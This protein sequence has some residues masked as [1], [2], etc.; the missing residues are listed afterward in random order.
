MLMQTWKLTALLLVAWPGQ[1]RDRD[2]RTEK[3]EARAVATE[4][5][6]TSQT[7]DYNS[8]ASWRSG[9][10]PGAGGDDT[11]TAMLDGKYSQRAVSSGLVPG[12]NAIHRVITGPAYGGNIGGSG[13]PLT[14]NIPSSSNTGAMF[15]H[16][17]S[18]SVYFKGITTFADIV[19]DSVNLVN[20]MTLSGRLRH[21]FVK[22]GNVTI[23]T[24]VT[25]ISSITLL[26]YNA[27]VTFVESGDLAPARVKIIGGHMVNE[28]D[29]GAD[30]V[31]EV[32]GG[33]L[34]QIGKML[35]TTDLIIS[36]GSVLYAPTV[37]VSTDNPDMW[38]L[39][40]YLDL[41][42]MAQVLQ[43]TDLVIGPNMKVIGDLIGTGNP[44]GLGIS[45]DLRHDNP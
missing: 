37:D 27:T 34:E 32:L 43:A 41:S 39:A 31:I 4:H 25:A 16:R 14:L 2:A 8:A 26:G 35:D 29:F 44:S 42:Q 17:G 9:Q 12:G 7:G 19:C 3:Q 23:A 5:V 1:W 18:G 24:D 45:I 6:W 10:V 36:A 30:T 22:E 28:R 13:T 33:R 11:D 21:V 38:L 40:G 20:A 15:V